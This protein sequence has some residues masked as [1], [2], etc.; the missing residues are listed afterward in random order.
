MWPEDPTRSARVATVRSFQISHKTGEQE[1]I[2]E[3]RQVWTDT[4]TKPK[5]ASNQEPKAGMHVGKQGRR[6]PRRI[7]GRDPSRQAPKHTGRQGDKQVNH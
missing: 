4:D 3:D 7:S 5:K 1:G 6:V 2:D